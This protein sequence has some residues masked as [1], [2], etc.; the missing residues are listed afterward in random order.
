MAIT[1][2]TPEKVDAALLARASDGC[3]EAFA[4]IVRRYERPLNA[5]CR[6]FLDP[7]AAEDAVQQT[8]LQAYLAL[9]AQGPETSIALGPWIY[10]I[11]RNCSIDMLRRYQPARGELDPEIGGGPRPSLVLE[12][13]D[14]FRGVVKGLRALPDEQRRALV[15]R[16]LEGL[17]YDEISLELGTSQG[18]VRQLIFRGRATLRQHFAAVAI[19]LQGCGRRRAQ[20][21]LARSS[22]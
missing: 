16:E 15:A 4:E 5:Y 21:R 19:P 11:A 7:A 1:T 13:R 10:R 12:R 6:R 20:S 22:S 17:S 14:E 3:D 9:R 2:F 18:A 8:F